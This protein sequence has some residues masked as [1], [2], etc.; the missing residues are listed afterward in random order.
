MLV[1]TSE[2]VHEVL[3]EGLLDRT[4]APNFVVGLLGDAPST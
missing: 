3:A 4:F 1:T 2:H